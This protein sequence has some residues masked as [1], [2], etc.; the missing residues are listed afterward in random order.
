MGLQRRNFIFNTVYARAQAAVACAVWRSTSNR[1]RAEGVA[2]A[3]RL[4]ITVGVSENGSHCRHI[5]LAGQSVHVA[6]LYVLK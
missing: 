6:H 4:T 3:P 5:I 1:A 2:D